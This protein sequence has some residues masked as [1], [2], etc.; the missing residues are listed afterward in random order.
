MVVG[1]REIH[2]AARIIVSIVVERCENL[3]RKSNANKQ[4]LHSSKKNVVNGIDTQDFVEEL[5]HR[6]PPPV[7]ES[8]SAMKNMLKGKRL[9]ACMMCIS[10]HS[11]TLFSG[12]K[13][14]QAG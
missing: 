14:Q 7:V 9:A 3:I 13:W 2:E 4:Q 12:N 10:P 5:L 1:G 11:A 8:Q 6:M